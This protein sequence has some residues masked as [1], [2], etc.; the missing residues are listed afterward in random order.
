MHRFDAMVVIIIHA[1]IFGIPQGL[2]NETN[3]KHNTSMFK[4]Y[5]EMI[6]SMIRSQVINI[7]SSQYVLYNSFVSEIH[8]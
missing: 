8:I 4:L 1:D 5:A 7:F 3:K 2:R 6:Q